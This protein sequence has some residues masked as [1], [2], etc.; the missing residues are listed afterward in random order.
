MLPMTNSNAAHCQP[1]SVIVVSANVLA[2]PTAAQ[3]TSSRLRLAV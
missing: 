1:P 3:A 2:I